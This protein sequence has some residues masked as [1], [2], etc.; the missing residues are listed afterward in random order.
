MKRMR[1]QFDEVVGLS[2]GLVGTTNHRLIW[3]WLR[4]ILGVLQISFSVG[5]DHGSFQNRLSTAYMGV[6]CRSNYRD[7]FKFVLYRGRSHDK[8]TS[9]QVNDFQYK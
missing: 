5:T 2:H 9:N 3:G 4:L 8:G 1:K 6:R 7:D